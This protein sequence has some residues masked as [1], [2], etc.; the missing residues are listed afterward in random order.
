MECKSGLEILAVKG[1]IVVIRGS[2]RVCGAAGIEYAFVFFAE[3]IG[4]E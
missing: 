3:D 2:V 4:A 1:I